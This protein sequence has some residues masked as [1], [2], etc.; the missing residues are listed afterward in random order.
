MPIGY[1]G[2]S[3]LEVMATGQSRE[4]KLPSCAAVEIYRVAHQATLTPDEL[5]VACV[6]FVQWAKQSNLQRVLIPSLEA[7]ARAA[8]ER[9][10]E[11]QRFNLRNPASSVPAIREALASTGMGLSF[12]GGLI[13]SAQPSVRHRFDQTFRDFFLSL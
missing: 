7:W 5:F 4:E 11:E 12:L 2:R 9:V 13:V 3:I 1:P 8:W 6:R 10:I